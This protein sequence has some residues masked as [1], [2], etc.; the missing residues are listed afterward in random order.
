MIRGRSIAGTLSRWNWTNNQQTILL[1]SVVAGKCALASWLPQSHW[2]TAEKTVGVL[3]L[4]RRVITSHRT[5]WL[6]VPAPGGAGEAR[7]QQTQTWLCF[8]REAT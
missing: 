3:S 4:A 2:D 1:S 5:H 6:H 7:N 8:R